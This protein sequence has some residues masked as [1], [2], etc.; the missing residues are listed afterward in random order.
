MTLNCFTGKDSPGPLV[1]KQYAHAPVNGG[2]IENT[3]LQLN[4]YDQ[5]KDG[6]FFYRQ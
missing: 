4:V 3:V 2:R 1:Q 6:R 5:N